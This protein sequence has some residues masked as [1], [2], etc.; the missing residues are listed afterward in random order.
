MSKVVSGVSVAGGVARAP[1]TLLRELAGMRRALWGGGACGFL[2]GHDLI[3]MLES[4]CSDGV[5]GDQQGPAQSR[6]SVLDPQRRSGMCVPCHQSVVLQAPQ[7]LGEDLGADAPDALPQFDRA[8]GAITQRPKHHGV[9]GV[10][11]QVEGE[12]G[13]AVGE[14]SVGRHVPNGA[15]QAT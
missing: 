7:R 8:P 5:D 10:G 2:G 6:E 9:P 15:R 3:A 13:A 12:A 4:P 1:L 11:E 14:E